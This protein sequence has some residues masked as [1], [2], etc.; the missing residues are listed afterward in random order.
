MRQR[1]LKGAHFLEK[2]D[3]MKLARELFEI[4]DTKGVGELEFN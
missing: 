3:D 1:D 4:W 2:L